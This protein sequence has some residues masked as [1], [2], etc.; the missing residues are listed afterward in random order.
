MKIHHVIESQ[1]FTVPMLHE[2]FGIA[3]Q[4]EKI[5]AR[6]GTQDYNNKIM[7]SL[8][9]EPSTRTRFSF[10]T[11]MLRLGGRI[12]TTEHAKEFSSAVSGESLEDT[13]KVLNQY[14]DVIVLRSDEVGGAKRA[15]GVSVIPVI[16]AGDGKG[17]Q[18]PTQA[19]LDLYTMYKEIQTLDG[20]KVAM[21]GDLLSGRTVRSLTYLLA[22]FERVKLYFVAPPA[23]QMRQDMLDYLNH[24]Q[25]W[26]TLESDFD[27]ILPEIDVIYQTRIEEKRCEGTDSSYEEIARKYYIQPSTMQ[28]LSKDAI[29]MHPFPRLKEISPDID[30]DPRA[31]YFRQAQNGISIRMALL[32]SVLS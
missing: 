11:A 19:L 5:I 1:Q 26:Y 14:V 4:M 22:K 8:F 15:S 10:E 28:K 20:L 7:A 29:I 12:L 21:V 6:G 3:G 32:T 25:V 2:L 18:H 23:L 31:A 17:G 16:N 9:Y 27:K 24:H 13:I 30:S